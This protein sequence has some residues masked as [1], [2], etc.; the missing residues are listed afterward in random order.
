[1]RWGGGFHVG[2]FYDPGNNW[3]FGAA[4]KSPQWF[5]TFSYNSI[6][7]NGHVAEPK[8]D[9][10]FPMVASVGTAYTG[11]DK[12]LIALDL[13]FFDFRD[14]NGFRQT[15]FNSNG[16][17]RGLGWQNVFALGTGVQ[18]Q[19]SD[20]LTLRAGYSFNLNPAGDSVTM[21]N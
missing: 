9:L 13:R 1:F 8:F 7:V 6:S 21:F 12:L 2:V 5:D 10:D 19:Y 11:I 16:T 18:Y 20:A 15:G 14:T 3:K 17:V 4:V